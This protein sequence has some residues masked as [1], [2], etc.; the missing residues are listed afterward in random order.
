MP[1]VILPSTSKPA[2]R[3]QGHIPE[4]IYTEENRQSLLLPVAP[5][6]LGLAGLGVMS[7][8][9]NSRSPSAEGS[10]GSF[11]AESMAPVRRDLLKPMSEPSMAS[12]CHVLHPVGSTVSQE[13]GIPEGPP[14]DPSCPE[15]AVVAT[16]KWPQALEAS[17]PETPSGAAC[18]FQEVTE[19]AVVAVDRQAVF[20]DTWSLAKEH[21][22]QER[23]KPEP[24]GLESS[25]PASANK[26]QLGGERPRKGNVVVPAQGPE[27]PRSPEGTTEAAAKARKEHPELP[28]AMVMGIPGTAERISTSS[29][30]GAACEA[31]GHGPGGP[32]CG[33]LLLTACSLTAR[34]SA[35][36]EGLWLQP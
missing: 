34:T 25:C 13:P 16:W 26:E 3:G 36:A 31:T 27:T 9:C 14:G 35:C 11:G 23:A 8:T 5:S 32:E 1:F 7:D 17:R 6:W 21:G 29:Q 2:P 18:G 22:Q 12:L 30:A 15:E 33:L 4:V 10:P 28:H 20:P 19:P 24:G